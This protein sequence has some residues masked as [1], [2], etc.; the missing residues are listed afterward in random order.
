MV[1]LLLRPL[2]ETFRLRIGMSSSEK[3]VVFEAMVGFIGFV[4]GST[5]CEVE[6]GVV[7]TFRT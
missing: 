7:G 3:T 6:A 1:E 4:G 5:S 2:L